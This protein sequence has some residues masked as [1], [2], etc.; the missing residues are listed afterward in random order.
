MER[1]NILR[2]IAIAYSLL[3]KHEE[4]IEITIIGIDNRSI[5]EEERNEGC[6][7]GMLRI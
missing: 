2:Q 7:T 5:G 6:I 1:S 4:R 3:F